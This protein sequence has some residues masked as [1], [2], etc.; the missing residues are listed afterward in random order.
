[1]KVILSCFSRITS[2][3]TSGSFASFAVGALAATVLASFA[4]PGEPAELNVASSK[5]IGITNG[6]LIL[7][8]SREY[9]SLGFRRRLHGAVEW[10][11]ITPLT[12]VVISMMKVSKIARRI[13][14]LCFRQYAG[15][16]MS[17][18]EQI[19]TDLKE[20][21]KAREQLRI[22]TLRSALSAF[23]YK[24]TET[25]KDELSQEEELAVLQ[26]L[27][28]QRNDSISEFSKAGR[29]DLADKEKQEK[30]I[31]SKYLP[32]QKSEDEIRKMVRDIIES[33]PAEGRN[34]GAVMKAVMPQMKGLADGN[35]VRQIVTEELK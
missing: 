10:S 19:S 7:F 5:T 1:M 32:A 13:I 24:R 25:G 15:K 35:L 17:V 6:F 4:M 3:E 34:Q 14:Q 33:L 22:D 30:E 11:S 8:T 21:M 2:R 23:T 26:K 27:V 9:V 20:A 31:L 12:I 28:K 29:N 18:K 16:I